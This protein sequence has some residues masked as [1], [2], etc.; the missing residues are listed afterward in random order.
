MGLLSRSILTRSWNASSSQPLPDSESER[1][2]HGPSPASLVRDRR[3]PHCGVRVRVGSGVAGH[4]MGTK[5]AQ[6]RATRA[7]TGWV[8]TGALPRCR[9]GP[10]RNRPEARLR[11]GPR[12]DSEPPRGPTRFRGPTPAPLPSGPVHSRAV[13]TRRVWGGVLPRGGGDRADGAAGPPVVGRDLQGPVPG[14]CS[15]AAWSFRGGTADGRRPQ[16]GVG[17]PPRQGAAEPASS[18]GGACSCG[19]GGAGTARGR[20]STRSRGPGAPGTRIGRL[21]QV[22]RPAGTRR[23][24]I[25]APGLPGRPAP[26][27]RVGGAGGARG[28]PAAT[29]RTPPKRNRKEPW[30]P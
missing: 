19:Q 5:G 15:A 23:R 27:G 11:T 21:I 4:S 24:R 30:P 17:W 20:L 8:R 28:P 9:R 3:G 18:A 12:P 7:A 29:G 13:L 22:S 2:Q 26:A 1:K 14:R 10:T 25:G 6:A 16:R